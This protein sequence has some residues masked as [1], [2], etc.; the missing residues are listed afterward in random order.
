ML[1]LKKFTAYLLSLL[2]ILSMVLALPVTVSAAET[3]EEEISALETEYEE[4]GAS[5]KIRYTVL[6]DGTA[7]YDYFE[8]DL[9]SALTM[10]RFVVPDTIAGRPV[11]Q[12]SYDAL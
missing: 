6:P 4:V 12:L 8:T 9:Y 10:T 3:A 2:I 7:R 5:G 11:T 1:K